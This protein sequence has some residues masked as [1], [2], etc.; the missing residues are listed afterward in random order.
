VAYTFD[1]ATHR[2]YVDGLE[3]GVSRATPDKA[4]PAA[5]TIG[6][7]ASG[8]EA[9]IGRLD[10]VTIHS[11]PL[12]TQEIAM[13]VQAKDPVDLPAAGA[14]DRVITQAQLDRL[15]EQ[16]EAAKQAWLDARNAAN[17]AKAKES[18]PTPPAEPAPS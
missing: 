10:D 7:G 12:L 4:A 18:E 17:K 9:F 1:G 2:L 5:L 14:Q 15:R 6:A 13:M 11:R 16:A 8:S 3:K